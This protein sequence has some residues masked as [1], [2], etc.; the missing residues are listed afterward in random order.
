MLSMLKNRSINRFRNLAIVLL[1][2]CLVNSCNRFL[3]CSSSSTGGVAFEDDSKVLPTDDIYEAGFSWLDFNGDF[4]GANVIANCEIDYN[5][6]DGC[7]YGN[8]LFLFSSSAVCSVYNLD[9]GNFDLM[10]VSKL[11]SY[12]G[13]YPHSNSVCFGHKLFATDPVPLIYTNVYNNYSNNREMDGVCFVY[14]AFLDEINDV[15]SFEMVQV[16]KVGFTDNENI[17]GNHSLNKSPYGNFL[18]RE[19]ELWVYLNMFDSL[20]TR[21][22]RFE[23][24]II[25]QTKQNIQYVILEQ[26]EI[27]E[28]FDV[29]LFR[30]IQGGTVSGDFLFSLEGFGDEL[31]P[32]FLRAVSLVTKEVFSIGLANLIGECEPEFVDFYKGILVIGTFEKNIY[33]VSL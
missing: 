30:N 16:I 23:L 1:G 15:F 33:F 12:K 14:R 6:Q 17:W 28:T 7:I 9:G 11:P 26:E 18:V 4:Q 13:F 8:W 32:G 21:F 10:C 5:P 20:T 27:K 3:S 22:F 25:G 2:C 24:P 19:N 31:A 29:F